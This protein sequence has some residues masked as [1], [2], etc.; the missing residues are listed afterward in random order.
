MFGALMSVE[1]HCLKKCYTDIIWQ[2]ISV[3]ER[4]KAMTKTTDFKAARAYALQRLE[5]DLPDWLTYHAI[6]HTRDDVVPATRRL[7]KMEGVTGEDYELVMIAAWFHDIGFVEEYSNNEVIAV[8]IAREVLPRF[9]YTQRQLD[10]IDGIIMAT[11]LPQQPET[12]LEE[13]MADA[14][15]DSLGR[16]DFFTVQDSLRVELAKVG[17]TFDAEAWY[18]NELDFLINHRYFTESAR[19]L[20]DV[21]KRHNIQVFCDLLEV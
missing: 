12:L 3:N 11:K 18:K 1:H 5:N 4:D 2:G 9:G 13:I 10:I 8:K 16:E 19:Q 20:R 15:M 14:D 6:Q 7:A 17:A 21:R